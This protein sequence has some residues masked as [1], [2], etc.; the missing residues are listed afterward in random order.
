MQAR[1]IAYCP[2]LS[3]CSSVRSLRF[4]ILSQRV[5]LSSECFHRR[6]V[7]TVLD[8]VYQTLWRYCDWDLFKGGVECKERGMKNHD[9]RPIS[10]F[11]L[12]MMQDRTI[13][14]TEGK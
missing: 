13:V 10:R 5:L 3:V 7:Q 2:A 1:P 12:E 11:I 6:I 8:F 4:Y 14:T 9:V